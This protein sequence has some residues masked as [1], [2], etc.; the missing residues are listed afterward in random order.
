MDDIILTGSNEVIIQ[1]VN[2]SLS[3]KISLKYLG[4]LHY[5]LG[6]EVHRDA[7]GLLLS[8]SKYIQEILHDT[9]MQECKGFQSPMSTP[10]LLLRDDKAPKTDG[11]V[12]RTVLGRLQYL[13]PTRADI[14]YAVS[15]L[16][17]FNISPS[18]F[19]WKVV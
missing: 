15:K 9:K 17:Q 12:Y 11:K 4:L 2:N 8:Q 1:Q 10:G 19:H 6:I 5:F 18:M 14:T 16:T 3:K 13:P 7:N